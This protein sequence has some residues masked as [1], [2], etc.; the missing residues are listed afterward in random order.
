MGRRNWA[1]LQNLHGGKSQCGRMKREIVS[2]LAQRL[3]GNCFLGGRLTS[4]QS[5]G[6]EVLGSEK[7]SSGSRKSEGKE[8]S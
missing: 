2:E 3:Q 8:S 7:V 5:E 1:V 6:D 4:F